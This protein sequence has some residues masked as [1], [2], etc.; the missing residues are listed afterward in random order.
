MRTTS[1]ALVSRIALL[2][3][4]LMVASAL[5]ASAP[6]EQVIYNFALHDDGTLPTN[7]LVADSAGNLYGVTARGGAGASNFGVVFELSPPATAGGAWTETIL[8]S[9]IGGHFGATPY[10]TLI[11]DK[12]GNLYGTTSQGGVTDGGTRGSGLVFELSPPAT[13]GGAW[14]ETVLYTFPSSTKLGSYPSGKLAFDASGNLYGTTWYGGVGTNCN[15]GPT[16]T[17]CGTVYKLT[18]PAAA[19][20]AWTH[21]VLHNFGISATDGALP[22]LS[23]VLYRGGKLFGTTQQGGANNDGTVFVL[24]PTTTGWAEHILH[25]FTGNDGGAPTGGLIIDSANNLYGT[26][27]WGGGG[28]IAT[29]GNQ[30]CGTIY[31]LSPPA[32][33]GGA[34]TQ[35]MLYAF[36]GG[37]DGAFPWASLWRDQA[38]SLYGT[39]VHG[40]LNNRQTSNNGVVFRLKPPAAAGADWTLVPL[41]EFKGPNTDG[42]FPY[43][44]LILVN[45]VFYG[46]L[47]E[48]GSGVGQQGSVYSIGTGH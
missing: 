18:A 41:H 16:Q 45:H 23:G 34:W 38:G 17:G 13:T 22:A 19:G 31:A 37:L 12:S 36:T 27:I 43:G 47:N 4:L 40:G 28:G 2:G 42:S 33:A 48:G 10:G 11:F 39:T 44:E 29:C 24:V 7:G 25:D 6:A 15:H 35:T 26:T 14:T 32:V 21:T 9:F 5:F 46:T 1:S 3:F 8:F 30:G 20:G